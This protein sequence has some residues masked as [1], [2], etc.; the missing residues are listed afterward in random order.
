[1]IKPIPKGEVITDVITKHIDKNYLSSLD[2]MGSGPIGLTID[3]VEKHALL[4][5]NNGNTDE[6]A[7]LIYFKETPKPL[8]LCKTN[9]SL[10]VMSVGS[11]KVADWIGKKITLEVQK[12]QSFGKTRPAVRVK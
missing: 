7:I 4:T 8:K 1:M 10:I 12:I 9:I 6:N 11:A 2:L 3:R 5:Y